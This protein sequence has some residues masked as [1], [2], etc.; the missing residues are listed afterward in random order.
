MGFQIF[1]FINNILFGVLEGPI[2]SP[3]QK[4]FFLFKIIYGL[5]YPFDAPKF[6]FISKIF[7]PNVGEDGFVSVDILHNNWTIALITNSIILSI[8]SLLDTPDTNFFLNQKAAKLYNQN[9]NRYNEIVEKYTS[10]Y[11]NYSIFKK[12]LDKLGI[13]DK[14]IYI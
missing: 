8:Q 4:G 5:R 10:K 13:K 7:H 3:Y 12:E 1:S 11:A 2:S 9:K 6:Y 14:F